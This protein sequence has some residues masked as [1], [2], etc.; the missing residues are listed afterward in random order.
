MIQIYQIKEKEKHLQ[1]LKEKSNETFLVFQ[2]YL[3][4]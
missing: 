3:G 2:T 4:L 1:D